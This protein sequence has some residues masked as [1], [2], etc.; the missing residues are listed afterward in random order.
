M[1]EVG[2]PDPAP[3]LE[4]ML[5]TLSCCASECHC[6]TPTV[7]W[8]ICCVTTYLLGRIPIRV[9]T[10]PTLHGPPGNARPLAR[11]RPLARFARIPGARGKSPG[12]SALRVGLTGWKG[13][14]WIWRFGR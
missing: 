1:D 10:T 14:V 6:S 11:K 4:R 2:C 9:D 13:R 7:S 8:L 12:W 5:S 3:E